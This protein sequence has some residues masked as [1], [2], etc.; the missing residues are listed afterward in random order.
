[1]ALKCPDCGVSVLSLIAHACG[2][3]KSSDGDDPKVIKAKAGSGRLADAGRAA[4]PSEAKSGGGMAAKPAVRQEVGADRLT[5]PEP[6]SK[7]GRP[8]IGEARDKPWLDCKPAMSERTYR[9]RLAE[10]RSKEQK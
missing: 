4:S 10:Q 7:R 5:P 2:R 1:M 3:G 6:Q 9:R 8:R